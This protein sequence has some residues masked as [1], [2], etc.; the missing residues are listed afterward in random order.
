MGSVLMGRP[1]PGWPTSSRRRAYRLEAMSVAR[2]APVLDRHG[3]PKPRMRGWIHRGAA[4]VAVPAV[5][6]L[7][8]AAPTARA[9]IACAIYGLTLVGLFTTSSLYHIGNW[10]DRQRTW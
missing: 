2:S 8:V 7:L 5:V 10:T 1:S 6:L 3:N 9:R 4:V